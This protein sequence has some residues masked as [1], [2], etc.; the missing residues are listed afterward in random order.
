MDGDASWLRAVGP[1]VVAALLDDTR[2][3]PLKPAN[4]IASVRTASLPHPGTIPIA[5]KGKTI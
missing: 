5:R 2:T 3:M 4:P 1:D